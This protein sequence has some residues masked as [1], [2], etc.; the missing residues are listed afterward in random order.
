MKRPQGL[1]WNFVLWVIM[2]WDMSYIFT[3]LA[4]SNY[5]IFV[6]DETCKDC[7]FVFVFGIRIMVIERR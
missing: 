6:T 7:T 1:W 4:F 3:P 5:R 2:H